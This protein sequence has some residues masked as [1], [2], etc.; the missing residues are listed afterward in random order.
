MVVKQSLDNPIATVPGTS[1]DEASC[2]GLVFK[3]CLL[4]LDHIFAA[5][6]T[7]RGGESF[8]PS[9]Q[10][11]LN[12]WSESLSISVKGLDGGAQIMCLFFPRHPAPIFSSKCIY[13]PHRVLIDR[14]LECSEWCQL[15][16]GLSTQ[17][18]HVSP[19]SLQ[20]ESTAAMFLSQ[21]QG[22]AQRLPLLPPPTAFLGHW[23]FGEKNA[24]GRGMK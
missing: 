21:P 10:P 12:T 23:F 6:F 3:Y 14:K 22:L 11:L 17:S 4:L 8:S 13:L 20:A 18:S 2:R 15:K 24:C 1:V 7:H 16:K 9:H 19:W 5:W